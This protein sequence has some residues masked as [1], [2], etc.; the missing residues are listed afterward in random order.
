MINNNIA[1][2]E[3]KLANVST[4]WL[5]LLYEWWTATSRSISSK[6]QIFTTKDLPQGLPL[7]LLVRT[8]PIIKQSICNSTEITYCSWI[9]DLLPP[10]FLWLLKIAK[11][12]KL[13]FDFFDLIRVSKLEF[14]SKITTL[15][16]FLRENFVMI[17]T[18][19]FFLYM[20][21]I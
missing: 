19:F 17:H 8:F 14:N 7:L 11:I 9:P 6:Q 20:R 15:L 13:E 16:K 4:H 12:P 3:A 10:Q 1:Q 21:T 5:A 2:R 18:N